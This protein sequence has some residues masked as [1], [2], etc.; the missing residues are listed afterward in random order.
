MSKQIEFLSQL[1]TEKTLELVGSIVSLSPETQLNTANLGSAVVKK[2]QDLKNGDIQCWVSLSGINVGDEVSFTTTIKGDQYII[3]GQVFSFEAPVLKV[4]EGFTAYLIQRR[5]NFRV[6][7]SG[8]TKVS[9]IIK[10]ANG[11]PVLLSVPVINLSLGGCQLELPSSTA[12]LR[13]GEKLS[14]E[15][16]APGYAPIQFEGVIQRLDP[17]DLGTKS[18]IFCGLEFIGMSGVSLGRLHELV[19]KCERE[20]RQR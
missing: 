16:L 20:S 10:F 3:R 19:L 5:D 11:H 15:L 8:P 2:F 4:S 6:T 13:S 17:S 14:G 1:T 7:I 18:V 12:P 9:S